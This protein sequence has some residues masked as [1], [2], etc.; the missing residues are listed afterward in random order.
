MKKFLMVT[1]A[2]GV[3]VGVLTGCGNKDILSTEY[4]F[5]KAQ[6]KLPDGNVKSC[7][8]DTWSRVDNS[9]NLR[10][11]CRGSGVYYSGPENIVLYNE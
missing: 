6:I 5:T 4:T 9:N 3:L 11:T 10:V 8:V 7:D 2:T 1:I